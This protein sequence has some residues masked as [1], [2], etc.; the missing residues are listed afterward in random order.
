MKPVI[1]VIPLYDSEKNSLWMLPGYMNII[2]EC[3]GIPLMLPLT[4]NEQ[5][6]TECIGLC[7]GFL[8]TGGQD[9]DPH[10]YGQ[11]IRPECGEVCHTRDFMESF[12]FRNALQS[13][14]PILGI[15]RG[16]QIMNVLLGGTLYQDLPT[17]HPS[18]ICHAMKP[19]YDRPV[20]NVTVLENTLLSSIIGNGNYAVNSYHHQAIC[21]L[22]NAAQAMAVSEDG[23]IEAIC[24]PKKKFIVG[25]QWHPEYAYE[26]DPKCTALVQAFLDTASF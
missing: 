11:N 6:L 21:D 15:C 14:T 1:G 16:I 19:P 8:L 13:D 4:T 26:K 10:L 12:I 24:V 23:L 20:H 9:V 22:A 5:Q 2:E 25:I 3:G 18:E 17:Q 7:H